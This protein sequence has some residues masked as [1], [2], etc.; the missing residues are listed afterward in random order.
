M[1]RKLDIS[2][3]SFDDMIGDG[4]E[5]QDPI[6]DLDNEIDVEEVED[7]E[8][9]DESLDDQEEYDNDSEDDE[10]YEDE[11]DE[12]DEPFGIVGE[13]ANTLGFELDS[14][15]DDS[16]EG[17]TDFV[18]D[19]SQQVAEDQLQELFSQYPQVQQHLDFLMAGGRSEDYMQAS[20]PQID[21]AAIELDEEDISAQR[22]VMG[23]YLQAK[24]HDTEFIIDMLDTLEEKG[25]LFSR[26]DN[27]RQELAYAQENY[28]QQLLEQQR[29][30]YERRQQEDIE[31]WN[32]VAD[33]IEDGNEFSGIRIPDR[34][35]A[36]FFEY[37]ST[38]VGPNGETQR[39]LDYR[40]SEIEMKLA[41]DYLVYSGFNLN[42]IIDKKAR[43]KSAESLR[44]RIIS[45]EERVKSARRARK[46]KQF[47]VDS[48]DMSALLG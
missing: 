25:H 30:E 37:I 17:L 40:E 47:D 41:M 16:I 21:F 8:E 32:G 7:D 12:S 26:A 15:Y 28:R 3:I 27:A 5:T 38:P 39:D 33:I 2:A 48:L 35:K 10:D 22:A 20:N 11:F 19:I 42:D 1:E 9:I 13:I 6:E 45:N 36:K 31:F 4:V 23:Q 14:D 29:A 18:R 43:T 34:E 44:E 24:G 46:S